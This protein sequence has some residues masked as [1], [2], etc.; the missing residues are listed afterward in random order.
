[1]TDYALPIGTT[2]PLKFP[3]TSD[4][5]NGGIDLTTVTSVTL[6]P[7]RGDGTVAPNWTAS[8]VAAVGES[9]VI[10]T[11]A[12]IMYATQ[13]GDISVKGIWRAEV[14]L[15]NT[16]TVNPWPAAPVTFRITDQYGRP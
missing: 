10:P 8:L 7:L 6:S 9:V 12:V 4:V 1:M 5:V 11:L 3:I 13:P 15:N 14:S 2:I 16:G